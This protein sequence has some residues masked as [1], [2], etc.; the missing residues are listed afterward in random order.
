MNAGMSVMTRA[1][2]TASLLDTTNMEKNRTANRQVRKMTAEAFTSAGYRVAPSDA[3]FIFVDIKRDSR[4]FQDGCRQLSIA[5][6]RAF[7]PLWNWARIS[8]GTPA[9]MEKAIPVF[10]KVLSAPPPAQTATY[11]HLDGLP[12]E[13]T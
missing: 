12:S 1:G 9:E 3:N 6:G 4:G 10:M 7:P 11:E 5:V 2:A 13:L 8:I